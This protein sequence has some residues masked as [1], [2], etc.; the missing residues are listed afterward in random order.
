MRDKGLLKLFF[1]DSLDDKEAL[2]LVRAMRERAETM[3]D[4]FDREILPVAEWATDLQDIRF[5]LIAA[6][7]GHDF[8][9]WVTEWCRSLERELEPKRKRA[10]RPQQRRAR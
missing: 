7:F 1:A 6:R 2:E 5:P 3:I 9:V 8:E 10:R 4:R